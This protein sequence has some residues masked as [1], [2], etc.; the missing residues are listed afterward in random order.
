MKVLNYGSLN[1]DYT[2]KVS[3]MV[4]PGETLASSDMQLHCGGKGLNQSIALARAGVKVYHAGMIGRDG[5]ELLDMCRSEGIDTGY[6]RECK[7][8]SGHAIIQVDPQGENCIL[9]YGGANQMNSLDQ[10]EEVLKGFGEGD[11]L[12]FQNEINLIAPLIDQAHNK[13]MR[14]VMNPSPF[15][16]AVLECS[17]DK[18]SV[19]LL[20][21]TEGYQISGKQEPEEICSVLSEWFPHSE[22]V[23][24]LGDKGVFYCAGELQLQIP[25][26]SMPVVDTTAAGDTFTGYY[27]AGIINGLETAS[28]LSRGCMAAALAIGRKGAAASIPMSAE[29]D[30]LLGFFD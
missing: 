6:I 24:T 15:N 23:L 2:Y 19:F 10:I 5:K 21:E 20:N 22:I 12:L 11:V 30:F 4:R 18:V 28:A 26:Y 25:A 8:K 3:H 1:Y 14:I 27:L 13:G 9:L 16:E 7:D 29:V 17:L